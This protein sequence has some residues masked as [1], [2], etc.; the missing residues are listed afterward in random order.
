MLLTTAVNI[1]LAALLGIGFLASNVLSI[2]PLPLGTTV[3]LRVTQF[4]AHQKPLVVDFNVP[5][6]ATHQ[7]AELTFIF[8]FGTRQRSF[9]DRIATF[10]LAD[11]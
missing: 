11:S 9:E 8:E 5:I 7:K 3:T 1:G 10:A 6:A 2:D 4:I